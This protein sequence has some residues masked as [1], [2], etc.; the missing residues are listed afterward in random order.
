MSKETG[1]SKGDKGR[2]R[3]IEENPLVGCIDFHLHSG[4]DNVLRSLNDIQVAQ[5]AREMG[6]R[7][8]GSSAWPAWPALRLSTP[9][10]G[11]WRTWWSTRNTGAVALDGR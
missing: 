3:A 8:A 9:G 10:T 11:A 1:V 2:L 4:P 6:M 5:K 7:G